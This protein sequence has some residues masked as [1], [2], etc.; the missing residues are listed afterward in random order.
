[1]A[2]GEGGVSF[3]QGS[4]YTYMNHAAVESL[5]PKHIWTAAIGLNNNN[6]K[7]W[8]WEGGVWQGFLGESA[9]RGTVDKIMIYCMLAWNCQTINLN[10]PGN[11]KSLLN[12][13]RI[14]RR[15]AFTSIPSDKSK[16]AMKSHLHG[17]EVYTAT[18]QHWLPKLLSVWWHSWRPC[19]EL[20]KSSHMFLD[21]SYIHRSRNIF[22][23]SMTLQKPHTS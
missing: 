14:S 15:V 13:N 3:L 7:T 12:G 17:R 18:F 10:Y 4:G 1:M 21:C 22:R 11:F 2:P 9:E 16:A 6:K 8:R 23:G 5:T 20:N 19:P